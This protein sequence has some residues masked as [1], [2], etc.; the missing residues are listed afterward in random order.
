M[1][2]AKQYN[3]GADTAYL[4]ATTKINNT[5]L[6]GLY[7]FTWQDH[8]R[9]PFDAQELNVV[10][11]QI[12]TDDFAVCL[13]AGVAYC[14]GKKGTEDLTATDTRLFVTYTF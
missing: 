4:K 1:I 10:V 3:G 9:S 5:V 6:Y 7:N 11:K 13:K 2:F 12:I 8:D 14:D